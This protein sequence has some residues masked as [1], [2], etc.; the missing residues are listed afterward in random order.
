[1]KVKHQHQLLSKTA[2]ARCVQNQAQHWAHNI[3]P[4]SPDVHVPAN[5][6]KEKRLKSV[7]ASQRKLRIDGAKLDIPRAEIL[8]HLGCQE[9]A[10][11]HK[12]SPVLR[13]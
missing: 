2:A 11:K 6:L 12:G 13:H 4:K 3:A 7:D 10:A 8:P 1:M 5:I 9:K